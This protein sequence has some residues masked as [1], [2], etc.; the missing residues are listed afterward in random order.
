MAEPQ[1][2]RVELSR[3]ATRVFE[4]LPAADRAR[5]AKALDALERAPST[6]GQAGQV[7]ADFLRIRYAVPSLIYNSRLELRSSRFGRM[8]EV[9]APL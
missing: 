3:Q 6:T 8:S 4:R 5:V 2:V 7:D 9:R 1:P